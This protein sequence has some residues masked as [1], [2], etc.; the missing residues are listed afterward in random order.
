MVAIYYSFMALNFQDSRAVQTL[1]Q[2]KGGG[3]LQP[4]T[5]SVSALLESSR[6]VLTS[7]LSVSL[8]NKD[9]L[10]FIFTSG[11]WFHRYR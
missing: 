6:G 3:T 1:P 2:N 10:T 11:A 7:V 5:G 9:Y 8:S 4:D